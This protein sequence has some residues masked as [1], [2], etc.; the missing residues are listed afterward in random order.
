MQ[1]CVCVSST[2]LLVSRND[3]TRHLR[4]CASF[5]S[6]LSLQPSRWSADLIHGKRS[7]ASDS[8]DAALA[9]DVDASQIVVTNDSSVQDKDLVV[10]GVNARDRPGLLYDIS[11]TLVRL[12]LQC[13]RTEAAVV[14][15]RSL[16]VWRCEQV[17]N[18]TNDQ[19]DVWESLR[20]R[21][22]FPLVGHDL[23]SSVY[24]PR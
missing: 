24:V 6:D 13:H 1:I 15:L 14:G 11:K 18:S 7:S 20:V 3:T 10:I 9:G 4:C 21:I 19:V 12:N 23:Y 16:S 2:R 22:S 8:D 17:D 5:L